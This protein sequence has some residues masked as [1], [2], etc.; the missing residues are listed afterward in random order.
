MA[1]LLNIGNS[2]L[3]LAK[4]W[5]FKLIVDGVLDLSQKHN[6]DSSPHIPDMILGWANPQMQVTL[7]CLSMLLIAGASA[8]LSYRVASLDIS[9]ALKAVVRLK[10]AIFLALQ[11]LPLKYHE[12]S[13]TS[14]SAYRVAYDSQSIQQIYNG[15]FIPSVSVT[16]TLVGAITVMLRL[17]WILALTSLAV[18]PPLLFVTSYYSRIIRNYSTQSSIIES[19]LLGNVQETLAAQKLVRILGKE[20]DEV[21]RFSDTAEQVQDV[22]LKLSKKQLQA[23]LTV[24][25]LTASGTALIYLVGSHQVLMGRLTLGGVLVFVSYITQ[26]YQPIEQVSGIVTTL[27][28]ASAGLQRTFEILDHATEEDLVHG[29]HR[30]IVGSGSIEFKNVRF[31]YTGKTQEVLSN[32]SFQID[33]GKTLA[34][35]GKSGQGK[36]TILS[37]LCRFYEPSHG[38]ILIDGQQISTF[39]K[40]SLR[41]HISL[42]LQDTLIFSAS[43]AENIRYGK[44]DATE[45]DI[46]AAAIQADAYEFVAKLPMGFST[47]IGDHGHALSGGQQQRI[48]IARAFLRDSPIVLLDEPTSALDVA[49]E[50]RIYS[51]LQRLI[52]DR[53]AILITHRVN[54]AGLAD[55][56]AILK[57]GSL[58]EISSTQLISDQELIRELLD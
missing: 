9:I 25:F 52:K 31:S 30:L 24:A 1:I 20:Q 11:Y 26:L 37:L 40:Q 23:S 39:S 57:N 28:A 13:R 7:L 50:R 41:S 15:V 48:G 8:F 45:E 5:P 34:I 32:C 44:T 18:L 12:Q 54:L 6:R 47:Q 49:T 3:F 56:V 27:A 42:L 22:S 38:C 14:D 17:N 33:H 46:I 16:L 43:V 35:L 36:S 58:N 53:T 21:R 29:A 55:R 4:P 10:S 51:A 19:F 2:A